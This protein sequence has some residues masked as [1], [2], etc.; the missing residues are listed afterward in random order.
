MSSVREVF[1]CVRCGVGWKRSSKSRSRRVFRVVVGVVTRFDVG[2]S[3][4]IKRSLLV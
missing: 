4:E 2:V 1:V 3:K